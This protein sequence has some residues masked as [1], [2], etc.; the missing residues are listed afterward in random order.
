MRE[1]AANLTQAAWLTTLAAGIAFA[2]HNINYSKVQEH[3]GFIVSCTL[4]Y[5]P[6]III[7]LRSKKWSDYALDR[8]DLKKSLLHY[9][10]AMLAVMPAFYAVWFAGQ[11]MLLDNQIQPRLPANMLQL[12][13]SH[14]L[15]IALPEEVFFR[16]YLQGQLNKVWPKNWKLFG[17]KWG[18][19]LLLASLIFLLMHILIDANP[20][21]MLVFFPAL[22]FGL[23]RESTNSILAPTLAHATSNITFLMAQ[24]LIL[25]L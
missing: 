13:M 4:L 3:K 19:G 14:L 12:S 5:L 9:T 11:V 20:Y 6:L 24:S 1:K 8:P 25:H 21:R 18:P 7:S 2:A 23:L 22:L 15:L 17:I 16:G 10:I